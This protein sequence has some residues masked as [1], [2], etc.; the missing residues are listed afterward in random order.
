VRITRVLAATA[1]AVLG[2]SVI[3]VAQTTTYD[4]G[5]TVSVH[6]GS[7]KKP[8]PGGLTF[9]FTVSDPSGNQ[10]PPVQTYSIMYEGG[11][12][13]T[14]LIPGCA[15]SKINALAT[16]DTSVC[17]A[18]SKMGSGSLD[19]L[20]GSAGQA[21]ADAS[22]CKGSL[23]LFNGG[24]GHAT[25]FVSSELATCPVALRQAIDMKYVTKGEFAGLEFTVPEMLRHQ[26]MLD[27]TVTHADAKLNTIVKKK[28]GK[29]VGYIESTGCKDGTRDMTVTFTDEQGASFPA[30]KT[31][32]K[33]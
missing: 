10:T 23:E 16:P 28:N 1:L 31:L 11:R 9:S 27:I 29:K 8:K 24:K 19:A 30:T 6:G 12:L 26:V 4:I 2:M 3:A 14:S 17:P 32:G 25:L 21:T 13:N 33:C 5:G 18:G 7:K 20:I 22:K 15:A